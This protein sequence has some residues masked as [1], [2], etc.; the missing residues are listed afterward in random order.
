MIAPMVAATDT[1]LRGIVL[2]AGPAYK[3]S[4]ILGYQGLTRDIALMKL[5]RVRF[6]SD[7]DPLPV[8][9]TVCV[10]VLVLQGAT[11]RQITVEQGPL[12]AEAFRAGGNRD[13]ALHVLPAVHLSF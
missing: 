11:D 2:L 8:A 13:V 6:F 1:L 3:G 5:P 9:R 10:P 7:Y 12:L 4:R